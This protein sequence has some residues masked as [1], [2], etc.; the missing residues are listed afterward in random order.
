MR[1]VVWRC[2]AV[3]LF[4]AAPLLAQDGRITL[5]PPAPTSL[6]PIDAHVFVLCG[7]KSHTVTRVGNV[8]KIHVEP[9]VQ[10]ELCD[11]PVPYLVRVSIG[12]LPVGEYRI[13]VTVGALDSIP[14]SRAFVVRDAAQRDFEIHPFAVP[15]NPFGLRLHLSSTHDAEVDR[16]FVGDVEIS[17][18]N[19]TRENGAYTFPAPTRG[20]GLVDVRIV[21][22]AGDSV[23]LPGALYYYD[24][25]APIDNSV[26]E[27][28]LFP[29]LFQGAGAHG[30]QWVSEA[31]IANPQPWA[32]ETVNH[33]FPFV[34]IFYPCGERLDPEF[35]ISFSGHGYPHGIALIA[36]RAE[37]DGLSFSLRVR[38]TARSAE[39][40][41]TQVPVVREGQM[42]RNTDLTLLD[43][44]ID[45]RY[46][47]KLRMYAFDY[48]EHGAYV[49]IDRAGSAPSESFFVPVRRTCDFNLCEAIP[50]YGELD[51]PS[52]NVDERVNVYVTIGD[53]D[54]PAWAFASITNNETQQVTIV[55]A[56]GEGGR[57]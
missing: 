5:D 36:P 37:A 28:I 48:G 2:F 57:P 12:T 45:P 55:T 25:G 34:C 22:K 7:E 11:P 43:I 1:R 39:G 51:L 8:I 46:R 10:V 6:T 16:V 47:T 13:E 42:F 19:L 40:Y 17:Q 54:S 52:G 9:G 53:A 32:V 29:V 49:T 4:F 44:P 15:T 21:P 24:F 56:D 20:R 50:W 18:A 27:R 30:S 41:G 14:A 23:T 33:V 31:A 26:F 3:C 38:D 35:F